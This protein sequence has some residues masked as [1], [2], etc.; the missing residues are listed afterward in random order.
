FRNVIRFKNAVVSGVIVI[1]CAR[2]SFYLPQ[3]IADLK[4]GEAF[5]NTDYVLA[6]S[7]SDAQ[8]QRWIMLSYDIFC[9]YHIN[10]EKRFTKYFPSML[11]IIRKMRGAI[12]KL[13]IKNHEE[14]CQYRWAFNFLPYSGETVGEMIEGSHS[15][16]NG[17]AASTKE[18][19]AGHRHDSLDGIINYW[20]WTKF[21]SMSASLYRSYIK[22]LDTLKTREKTFVEY[23]ARF[24]SD[25][26]SKWEAIDDTPRSVG[27]R[28][29]IR[30]SNVLRLE[31]TSWLSG[32]PTQAKAHQK[33]VHEEYV[34]ELA[35]T[36]II[37]EAATISKG[38]NLE[39]DQLTIRALVALEPKS[40]ADDKKL[41]SARQKLRNDLVDWREKQ[42]DLFPLLK[43]E[44]KITSVDYLMPEKER[45]LLPSD[46]Q[47]A[48]RI[49][50]GLQSAARAE[51]EI[52]EGRAHDCL[53]EVRRCIQTYNHHIT[54][55]ANDVR[56]QRYATRARGIVDKLDA[57]TQKAADTYNFTRNALLKLGLSPT[58][59]VLKPL[60]TNELWA[61]NAAMPPKLGDSRKEDPWFW[62]VACPDGLSPEE[63]AEFYLES[64]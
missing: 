31:L 13:H 60:L 8:D 59:P 44:T 45:L 14:A 38:L 63:K 7:L 54:I 9:S 35:G 15:E 10:L 30:F 57:D 27:K 20:N 36:G 43:E 55:K 2:H 12:P 37:G 40:S 26:I 32:P 64:E 49:R 46:F 48:C 23:S 51:Y 47:E 21:H 3:G 29:V 5:R 16:Q 4:L 50:L 24:S 39:R 34:R 42:F 56:G 52:R 22:C 58:D 25:L 11:A 61:K 53:D 33:L 6:Y 41:L 19:N 62:H 18:M 17:A 28:K 1:Q